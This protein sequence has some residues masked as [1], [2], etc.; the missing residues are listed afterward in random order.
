MNNGEK[1]MK[2]WKNIIRTLGIATCLSGAF[3]MAFGEPIMGTIHTSV[4]TVIGI[5]GIGIITTSDK[6]SVLE[7]KKGGI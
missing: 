2:S 6:T 4:A 3:L 1:T 5:V 7:K